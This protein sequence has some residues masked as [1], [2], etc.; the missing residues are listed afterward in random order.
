MKTRSFLELVRLRR[1]GN[2]LVCAPFWMTLSAAATNLKKNSLSKGEAPQ[3]HKKLT[4]GR[5]GIFLWSV[6]GS[7]LGRPCQVLCVRVIAGLVPKGSSGDGGSVSW[8]RS[9][10][11]NSSIKKEYGE[12]GQ[13]EHKW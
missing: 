6:V 12:R 11:P 5:N 2:P 1:L 4:R 10:F 13:R 9:N 8:T 3:N 7:G